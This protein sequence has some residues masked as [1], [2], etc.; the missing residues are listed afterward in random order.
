VTFRQL[1]GGL[2]VRLLQRIQV[3]IAEPGDARGKNLVRPFPPRKPDCESIARRS[4]TS[5]TAFR[6]A[7]LF[8][9]TPREVLNARYD[10]LSS[11]LTE[12]WPLLIPYFCAASAYD[13][14]GIPPAA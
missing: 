14:G 2:D 12:N 6:S 3:G 9:K 5:L 11:G 13:A 4:I 7:M 10:V 8:L 1:L